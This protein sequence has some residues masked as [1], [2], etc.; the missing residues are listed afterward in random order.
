MRLVSVRSPRVSTGR[1]RST[2]PRYLPQQPSHRPSFV[3]PG[4]CPDIQ[5]PASRRQHVQQHQVSPA[6][7]P[8]ATPARSL[9]PAAPRGSLAGSTVGRPRGSGTDSATDSARDS[10][11]R[12]QHRLPVAIT[13][14][15][16]RGVRHTRHAPQHRLDLAGLDPDAVDLDLLIHPVGHE[17]QQCIVSDAAQGLRSV[18]HATPGAPGP[19]A[20]GPADNARPATRPPRCRVHA[21][22]AHQCRP[23]P[24]RNPRRP[25][26]CNPGPAADTPTAGAARRPGNPA[27]PPRR[28]RRPASVEA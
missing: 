11:I 16:H 3:W 23:A 19:A 7:S 8:V 2:S 6:A 28:R 12:Q 24:D 13:A 9:A 15:D 10:H 25:P 22:P 5:L 26:T 27:A 17:T 14:R 4:Q 18:I 21:R 20:C 1:P